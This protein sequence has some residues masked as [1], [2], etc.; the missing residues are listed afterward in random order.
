[1][2]FMVRYIFG[3]GH[4]MVIGHL[5]LGHFFRHSLFVIDSSFGLRNSSFAVFSYCLLAYFSKIILRPV[6]CF[7][8]G[9]SFCLFFCGSIRPGQLGVFFA[10]RVAR[11]S[12]LATDLGYSRPCCCVPDSLS[13]CPQRSV[14]PCCT[15]G[16]KAALS[17]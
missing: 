1:M 5:G 10:I 12:R 4:S 9:R 8:L 13:G 2:V 11:R 6:P 3:I 7:W 14:S 15:R 16:R 17:H